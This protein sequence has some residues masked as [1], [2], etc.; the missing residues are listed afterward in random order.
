M[1][2][3]ESLLPG[4]AE[5]KRFNVLRGIFAAGHAIDV[6]LFFVPVLSISHNSI[7]SEGTIWLSF[8][9]LVSMSLQSGKDL[10]FAAFL[11]GVLLINVAFV[12]LA[13]LKPLRGVF[14]TGAILGVIGFCLSLIGGPSSPEEGIVFAMHPL[15]IIIG[16]LSSVAAML[17]FIIKPPAGQFGSNPSGGQLLS[18]S[19]P[20][21]DAAAGSTD[22]D[23]AANATSARQTSPLHGQPAVLWLSLGIT[24]LLIL[25]AVIAG[26][27]FASQQPL[28]VSFRDSYVPGGG[29]VLVVK[30]TGS[31]LLQD[32]EVRVKAGNGQSF[33]PK[34]LGSL[35]AGEESELGWA[36]LDGWVLEKGETITL[37][38]KGYAD[39]RIVVP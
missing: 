16:V 4:M 36:E 32:C 7:F 30:N 10:G 8:Q 29:R 22:D 2:I 23:S 6:L 13:Y 21:Y 18:S 39:K 9:N 5:E 11:I 35:A 28:M 38:S 34:R 15:A 25:G 20:S 1:S 24:G 37:S 19:S 17:G 31:V 27:G 3:A 26:G 14:L 33:G 12:V